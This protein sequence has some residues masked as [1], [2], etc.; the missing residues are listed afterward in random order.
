MN[1]Y[2]IFEIHNN[3]YENKYN[4]QVNNIYNVR[5]Q[6]EQEIKIDTLLDAI[7]ENNSN[8]IDKEGEPN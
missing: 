7:L 2:K 4:L 1:S 3:E 5:I 6:E 8:N